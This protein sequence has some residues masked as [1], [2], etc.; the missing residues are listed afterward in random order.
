MLLLQNLKREERERRRRR[1]RKKKEEEEEE[2]EE[3][4]AERLWTEEKKRAAMKKVCSLMLQQ[5]SH[6][7]LSLLESGKKKLVY[8]DCFD[9]FFATTL[10]PN[11]WRWTKEERWPGRNELGLIWEELR[12]TIPEWWLFYE[13]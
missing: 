7:K 9:S 5:I 2:K 4:C 3:H 8:A 11:T 12:E 13:S 6:T 1:G 10:N